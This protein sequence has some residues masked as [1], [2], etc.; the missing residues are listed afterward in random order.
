MTKI[1]NM[2]LIREI[3]GA[4]QESIAKI[5]G[6]SR[7]TVS[8][9]ESGSAKASNSK[10]EKLSIF[11]GIGP[12]FFYDEEMNDTVKKMLTD[13]S[14]REEEITKASDNK[15]NKV[16]EISSILDSVSFEEA[17]SRFMF[18]MKM[19]LATADE[20]KLD[21]LKTAVVIC[22][23]MLKRLNAVIEIREN[24]EIEKENS[25]QETL[26]DLLDSLN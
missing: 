12:E 6:V 18:S 1:N 19:L 14:K 21:D 16:E 25:N 15:R 10:L 22:E 8:L 4:T 3:Y 24:E 11:Y 26:F 9:W 2:K 23:K 7:S 20:G 13:N 5:A 17:R